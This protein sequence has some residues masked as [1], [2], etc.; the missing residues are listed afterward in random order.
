MAVPKEE[1]PFIYGM[2]DRGGEHLMLV[3]GKAKGWVL[4][5]EEVRANPGDMGGSNYTDLADKGFGL[6]VRLNHAYGSDGTI[7]LSSKYQDFAS[8]WLILSANHPARISG[9][10]ATR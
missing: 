5:T 1:S 3:D 9:L 8:G 2:H 10:S 6:I 4:V 7:P